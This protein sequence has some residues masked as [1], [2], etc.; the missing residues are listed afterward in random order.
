MIKAK[1]IDLATPIIITPRSP[2][3]Y[4]IYALIV[5]DCMYVKTS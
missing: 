4:T 1:K 5:H 3:H 2:G